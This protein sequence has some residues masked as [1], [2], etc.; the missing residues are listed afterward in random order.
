MNP[1]N[2]ETYIDRKVSFL[3]SKIT[4]HVK[5]VVPA[6]GI[7][8]CTNFAYLLGNWVQSSALKTSRSII[9]QF[10]PTHCMSNDTNWQVAQHMQGI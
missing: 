4:S 8:G 9:F 3:P 2:V 5:I 1:K 10:E 6:M 7:F